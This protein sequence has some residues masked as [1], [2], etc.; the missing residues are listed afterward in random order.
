MSKSKRYDEEFKQSLVNLYQTGKTQSELCK[1][2]GVSQTALS[3]WIKQ[4]SQVKLEDNS[5]LTAK[6]IQDLQKRNAQLEEEN[7]NLKKSKCHIHAKLKVRL[8]AVYRLRFEHATTTLCR[9]LHVNR[10]TYYKFLKHKPSKREL[11]NQIYRKQILQIYTKANKRLGVKSIKVI[12]QRD[13][14]TKISEGRIYRLMK[15]MALPKMATVKPKRSLK[16]V[17][18]TYPQ[19][20]LKQEFNPDQP[21]QVWTTDFTYISIGYKKYVYLCAILDLYSRKC[22]AWKLSHRIDAKLACDTLELALNKRKIEG[23]LLFHSDQGSQF[24]AIEFRKIIDDNNIMH[25]FSKPGYP[26]DN[27]VTEAFFKYLKHRQ[28]NRKNYQNMKQVQLDCF[29]YIE[30]FYNNYNPHSANLGLTPNQKEE[31]Y[32]NSIN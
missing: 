8:L 22:I 30:N 26:Y 18:K 15:N 21:N 20:L 13:Y 6:Q 2:Y 19:N 25:S 29:E 14:D 28:I 27:A 4:Y 32:F 7:L 24:K 1:D 9:V 16:E 23:T 31:N 17:Q 11:D 12:L 3:K 5:V 10:S